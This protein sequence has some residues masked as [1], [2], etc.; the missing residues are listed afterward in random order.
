MF[1]E[2]LSSAALSFPFKRQ[3]PLFECGITLS[4]GFAHIM[5]LRK[6]G[7]DDAQT[8]YSGMKRD[9]VHKLEKTKTGSARKR[10][11]SR[12]NLLETPAGHEV[13][14]KRR[15]C[16][17]P[18]R[19]RPIDQLD[20][21]SPAGSRRIARKDGVSNLVQMRLFPPTGGQERKRRGRKERGEGGGE[22]PGRKE[23]EGWP[24]G[25]KLGY[26]FK[27]RQA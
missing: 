10:S 18:A 20:W 14:V 22:F 19:R 2:L 5:A 9:K 4:D 23:T 8:F 11:A 7:N 26:G 25:K 1:I 24:R 3:N 21:G 16:F 6:L 27:A 17:A 15:Y 12:P 13:F